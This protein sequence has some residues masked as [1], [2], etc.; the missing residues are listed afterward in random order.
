MKPTAKVK[1]LTT[2]KNWTNQ[3]N[4]AAITELCEYVAN[5]DSL[6]SFTRSKGFAYMT[7][8]NWIAADP[9]RT[10]NYAHARE[11]REDFTFES[12]D[13][14]SKEAVE[15]ETAVQVAGLRLKADNI[16][17]KLA[18][19]SPRFADKLAIGGASDLPPIRQ[20]IYALSNE[21]LLAIARQSKN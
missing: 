18:R 10:V 11:T 8:V 12:L 6:L 9:D 16:K 2:Y 17:W 19:M 14:V 7:V 21:E 4:N 13:G 15:A 1:P 5:G 20:Q 3:Q